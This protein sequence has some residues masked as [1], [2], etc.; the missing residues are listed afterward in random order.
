MSENYTCDM[1]GQVH[2]D[3]NTHMVTNQLILCTPCYDHFESHGDA[4]RD[5]QEGYVLHEA[6]LIQL[7]NKN[8]DRI[9]A[10]TKRGNH[11]REELRKL[12]ATPKR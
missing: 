10:I 1:C 2:P 9:E 11:I 3:H 4:H 6:A 5:H 7:L 8:L 12:W